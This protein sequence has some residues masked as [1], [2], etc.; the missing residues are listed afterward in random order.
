VIYSDKLI[1][2]VE[3]QHILMNK[4]TNIATCQSQVLNTRKHT[5]AAVLRIKSFSV[6]VQT[7]RHTSIYRY[8]QLV[9]TDAV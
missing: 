8:I 7:T 1:F 4:P 5:Q 2:S 6:T 3:T 9:K